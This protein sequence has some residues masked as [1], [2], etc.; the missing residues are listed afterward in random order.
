MASTYFVTGA[1]GFIGSALINRLL[2]NNQN[3]VGIDNLNDYYDPFLKKSRIENINKSFSKKS[4]WQ[5]IQASLED[6]TTLEK[7]FKKIYMNIVLDKEAK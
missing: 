4:S 7:I 5:F 6:F 1:A 2:E 3:V